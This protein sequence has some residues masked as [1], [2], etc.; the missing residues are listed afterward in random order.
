MW[1][2]RSPTARVKAEILLCF[3]PCCCDD[4][5]DHE[6]G[7]PLPVRPEQQA[8]AVHDSP[9]DLVA[10]DLNIGIRNGVRQFLRILIARVRRGNGRSLD[11]AMRG[12]ESSDEES[13]EGDDGATSE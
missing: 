8:N 5:D 3:N 2:K 4:S 7:N 12:L 11:G 10:P 6:E 9:D 13:L 1:I